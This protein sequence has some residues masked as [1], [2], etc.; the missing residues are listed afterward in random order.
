MS[1]VAQYLR[2]SISIIEQLDHASIERMVE[3]LATTRQ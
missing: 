3:I 2:E 1:F